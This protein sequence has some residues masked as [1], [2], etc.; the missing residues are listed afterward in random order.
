MRQCNKGHYYDENR[1]AKCPYCENVIRQYAA[2]RD[3]V[4]IAKGNTGVSAREV[5]RLVGRGSLA[6]VADEGRTISLFSS[7]K[8]NDFVTGW[9]VCIEGTEYGRDFRLHHGFNRIGRSGSMDIALLND[10]GISRDVHCQV[11][12][13]NK[14]NIFFLVPSKGNLIY[15]NGTPVFEA[16]EI[17]T[18]DVISLGA[19][20]LQLIAFCEGDRRW[21][22]N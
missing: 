18:G 19:T 10:D 5:G 6:P 14:A 2:E 17:K 3:A 8:G 9:L 1:Y 15:L 20:L 7:M 21:E 13:E 16:I 11:V 12:Y 22:E 4:T